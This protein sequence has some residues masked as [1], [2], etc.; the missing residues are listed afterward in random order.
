MKK[1]RPDDG[2]YVYCLYRD[3]PESVAKREATKA[4]KRIALVAFEA[5]QPTV[6]H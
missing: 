5:A 3:T 6:I 1:P 4:A 2:F